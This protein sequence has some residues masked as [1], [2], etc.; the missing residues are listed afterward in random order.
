[1]DALKH[2]FEHYPAV[3]GLG[4]AAAAV[5]AYQAFK[6]PRVYTSNEL[7]SLSAQHRPESGFYPKA[8]LTPNELHFYQRLRSAAGPSFTVLTQVGLGAMVDTTLPEGDPQ[9]DFERRKF[10]G[11]LIDFVIVDNKSAEVLVVVELDDR[12]HDKLKDGNRDHFLLQAGYRTLRYESRAKP[13]VDQLR[14]DIK[15]YCLINATLA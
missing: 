8:L 5:V 7:S 4:L 15:R 1:M 10:V 12:T 3:A 9:R 13:S 6:R 11:K 2:F 14:K